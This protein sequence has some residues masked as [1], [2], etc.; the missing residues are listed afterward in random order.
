L[1]AIAHHLCFGWHWQQAHDL[2]SY[3]ELDEG[4][5]RWGA[6]NTLIQLYTAMVPPLGVVTRRDEG[7]IFSQLGLLYGRL[8]DYTQSMFY[9]EQALATE[10]IGDLRVSA[11]RSQTREK[12]C[13][14]G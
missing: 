7:Q 13:V 3:E 12:Y 6:W 9:F 2:L 11:L 5:I 8:G 10:E 1:I 4:M 14:V